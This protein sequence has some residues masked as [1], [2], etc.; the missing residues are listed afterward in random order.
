MPSLTTA[1]TGASTAGASS[2]ALDVSTV[3]MGNWT[4]RLAAT[5]S[6]AATSALLAVQESA[7]NFV[8]DIRTVE[9][10]DVVSGSGPGTPT[11]SP[12]LRAYQRSSSRVGTVNAKLRLCVQS[13][14][15]GG[16]VSATLG[17]ES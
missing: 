17:I 10:Y 5:V 12:A 16:T 1:L 4:M 3:P 2:P 11:Q 14:G 8:S 13:I 9:V 7:D 15:V 6:P